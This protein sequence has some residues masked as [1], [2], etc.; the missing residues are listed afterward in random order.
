M[1]FTENIEFKLD[2]SCFTEI[3]NVS[4]ELKNKE[5]KKFSKQ[6]FDLKKSKN[7]DCKFND[8]IIKIIENKDIFN[9]KKYLNSN[10]SNQHLE[11]KVWDSFQ[12]HKIKC[13][14]KIQEKDNNIML[15][16][17]ISEKNF[18]KL[19]DDIQNYIKIELIEKMFWK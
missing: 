13:L 11:I 18:K 17:Y 7:F 6:I 14:I 5:I 15:T 9:I 16:T 2:N 1:Q 12:G 19:N 3:L 10:L 4:N 8:Y